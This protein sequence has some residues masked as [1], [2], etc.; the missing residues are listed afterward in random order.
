VIVSEH[1]G[2]IIHID[3]QL[4]MAYD[5]HDSKPSSPV[6]DLLNSEFHQEARNYQRQ[7][8]IRQHSDGNPQSVSLHST[9]V[10]E[11]KQYLSSSRS[12]NSSTSSRASRPSALDNPMFAPPPPPPSN[13]DVMEALKLSRN[14][15]ITATLPSYD[16]ITHS[17][18]MQARISLK[19]LMIKKWRPIFWITYGN[20]EIL[21]FRS[22]IDFQ[23]WATNPYLSTIEREDIVKL[24]VDF[25]IKNHPSS[26]VRCYRAFALQGKNYGKSGLMHTFKLEQWMHYGPVILGAFASSSQNEIA[27]FHT[28]CKEIIRR[29]KCGLR[30]YLSSSK[31]DDEIDNHS[32]RSSHSTKSA[33]NTKTPGFF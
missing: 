29:Q 33:P 21:M 3:Q 20:S 4:T 13:A 17:G 6:G 24:R 28:L 14:K 8:L 22:K 30:H 18:Y 31:G 10:G 15:K 32:Q 12:V 11:R 26:G 5:H 25:K 27:A 16:K 9:T 23:E 19:S 2:R 7:S 1:Q